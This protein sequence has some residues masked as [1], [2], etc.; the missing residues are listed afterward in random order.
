MNLR[1]ITE[2]GD[3]TES[4]ISKATFVSFIRKA[5]ETA[6]NPSSAT[7]FYTRKFEKYGL[8]SGFFASWNTPAFFFSYAWLFFRGMYWQAII[9]PICIFTAYALIAYLG[10]SLYFNF[11]F[12]IP[13]SLLVM[14]YF[15]FF[16][17]AIYFNYCRRRINSGVKRGGTHP[18][19]VVFYI[20]IIYP[21][22]TNILSTVVYGSGQFGITLWQWNGFI[23]ENKQPSFIIHK[24]L[25][26]PSDGEGWTIV[27][28][29]GKL[30]HID[31]P[32]DGANTQTQENIS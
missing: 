18:G 22:L 31:A 25:T 10:T 1:K 20:F 17:N 6:A 21:L 30:I 5:G 8:N 7:Q 23:P 9:Y 24:N 11:F 3:M 2:R 4:N 16:G 15:G 27:K 32:S 13:F 26:D 19:W 29:S 14:L 12:I 28:P